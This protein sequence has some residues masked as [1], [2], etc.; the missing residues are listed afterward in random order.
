M[1]R[2]WGRGPWGRDTL[3]TILEVGVSWIEKVKGG[4]AQGVNRPWVG[5]TGKGH[6]GTDPGVGV[7]WIAEGGPGEGEELLGVDRAGWSSRGE[8]GGG[9]LRTNSEEGILGAGQGERPHGQMLSREPT[10]RWRWRS[11]E[12]I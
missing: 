3:G 11:W 9:A 5:S 8:S 1:N 12:W 4:Q 10:C 2:P 6:P 7:P